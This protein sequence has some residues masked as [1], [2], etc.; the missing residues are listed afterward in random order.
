[1]GDQGHTRLGAH[2]VGQPRRGRDR[3]GDFTGLSHVDGIRGA[4]SDRVRGGFGSGR[5]TSEHVAGPGMRLKLDEN[6][7]ETLLGSL[8]ALRHE[9]DNARL[10][11]LAGHNDAEVWEGAQKS[12]RFFITQDL[13][14][15]DVRKFKPGTH[16]GLLLVRL[17]V[18]G[19]GALSRRILDVFRNEAVEAWAN[20][21]V[22]V[23]DTKIRVFRPNK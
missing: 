10:E 5:L 13:D 16:R 7:P 12:G 21:F 11:G 8:A 17:R 14:F 9:V 20:C 1:V 6:L 18:P 23:T 2:G 22:I 4:G 19:R 15:S 3:G